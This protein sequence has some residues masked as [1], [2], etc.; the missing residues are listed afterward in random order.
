MSDQTTLQS[1][2]KDFKDDFISSHVFSSHLLKV[3]GDLSICKTKDCGLH[4]DVCDSCGDM[5]THYNSC[6]NRNCPLCQMVE[7]EQWVHKQSFTTLNGVK[8]FHVVFTIPD[9]LHSLFLNNQE[10]CYK[11]LFKASADT[12]HACAANE[13]YLGAK[14]GFTSVLHTWGQNLSYHPHIHIIVAGGGINKFDKWRKS[15][16]KFFLPVKALSKVFKGI[17]K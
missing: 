5:K 1:I 12:L 10:R 2:L 14:I 7:K 6:R 8:Y 15:K 13:D 4:S 3:L 9:T 16:D 17:L 11:L